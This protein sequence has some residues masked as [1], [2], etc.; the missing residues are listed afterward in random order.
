MKVLKELAVVESV[1]ACL[2]KV[3]LPRPLEEIDSEIKQLKN[4]ILELLEEVTE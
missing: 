1:E 2:Y 4:E 3:G